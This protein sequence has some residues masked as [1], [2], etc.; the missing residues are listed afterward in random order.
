MSEDDPFY[1]K[2]D[3]IFDIPQKRLVTA[4]LAG[5]SLGRYVEDL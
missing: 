5:D 3:M 1:V 4:G 2:L